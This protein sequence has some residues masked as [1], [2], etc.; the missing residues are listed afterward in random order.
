MRETEIGAVAKGWLEGRGL[1]VFQEVEVGADRIDL[2]GRATGLLVAVE[3]KVGFGLDVIAQAQRWVDN[4]NESW[5]AV[6]QRVFRGHRRADT[7]AQSLGLDVCRNNGIGVLEIHPVREIAPT[8]RVLAARRSPKASSIRLH[9]EQKSAAP[10]GTNAG[11]YS[12]RFKRACER[13]S[14]IVAE[15]PGI[16]LR[17]AVM[18]IDHGYPRR[19]YAIATLSESLNRDHSK[20]KGYPRPAELA[21]IRIEGFGAKATLWPQEEGVF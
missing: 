17:Q 12:T 9:A 15:Q 3:C 18:G 16:T 2:V 20:T 21:A 19:A 11:G 14:A 6:P 5:V 4:A 1:E 8:V 10:A 13:L 7:P